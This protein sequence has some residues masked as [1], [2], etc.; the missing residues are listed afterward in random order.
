MKQ[1]ISVLQKRVL[2]LQLFT[3]CLTFVFSQSAIAQG[4]T[5]G[6]FET[7]DLTGW[8]NSG[9]VFVINSPVISQNFSLDYSGGDSPTNGVISQTLAVSIGVQYQLVFNYGYLGINKNHQLD[10][11]VD[12]AGGTGSLINDSVNMT[13][14]YSTPQSYNQTFTADA[15]SITIRL[16]DVAGNDTVG[17]DMI[18]DDVFVSQ[19]MVMTPPPVP[20]PTNNYF[21]L[22]LMG[23][24]LS[25]IALKQISRKKTNL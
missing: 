15:G 12:G 6:G 1:I 5:N 13:T 10:I 25:F 21:L 14:L 18:I 23:A 16:S 22:L 20:V 3:I 7:G 4:L 2:V 9:N 8:T 19:L 17:S 24:L 11:Q